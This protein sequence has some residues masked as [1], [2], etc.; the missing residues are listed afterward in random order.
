MLKYNSIQNYDVTLVTLSVMLYK[1]DYY[2][3]DEM[4]TNLQTKGNKINIV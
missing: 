1:T 4:N 3:I 2:I